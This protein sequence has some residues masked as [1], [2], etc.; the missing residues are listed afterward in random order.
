MDAF[1]LMIDKGAKFETREV[2]MWEDCGTPETLIR[3]NRHFLENGKT[4]IRKFAGSTIVPPVFI[5]DGAIIENSKIGPY[6]SIAKDAKIKDS[7]IS[8]SIINENAV[9]QNSILTDS[10]I[11]EDAKVVGA[12]GKLNVGDHSEINLS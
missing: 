3:T 12:S 7:T 6:V 5:E 8:D 9:V 10:I 1:Q 11:G 4:K 2:T